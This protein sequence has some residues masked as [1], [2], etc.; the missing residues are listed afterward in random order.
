MDS[1]TIY[2]A[3]DL[4]NG[5]VV[6]LSQGDPARQTVYSND[7]A[8]VARRWLTAAATWLHVVDLDAAFG[9]AGARNLAALAAILAAARG[10]AQVQFGG[11]LRSL[12]DVEHVLELGADRALLGTAAVESPEMVAEAVSRFGVERIGVAID[13]RASRVRVRGWVRDTGVD[14]TALGQGLY[15]MGVRVVVLTSIA[16]DGEGTGVDVA[17]TRNLSESTGLHVIGSGGAKSLH[18]VR[19]AKEA[20]IAGL[21]IGRALYEGLVDLKEALRC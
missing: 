20:G 1:F 19:R 9:E 5:G 7:P 14:P 21:V 10:Q 2:P 18:D 3:I 8:D 17:A 12:E 16:R 15:E 4:R 6:R 13:V 11:G